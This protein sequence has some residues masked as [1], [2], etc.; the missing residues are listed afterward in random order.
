MKTP[1]RLESPPRKPERTE[2]ARSPRRWWVVAI[3]VAF[4]VGA[5]AAGAGVYFW[6]QGRASDLEEQLEELGGLE[7]QVAALQGELEEARTTPVDLEEQVAGLQDRLDATRDR[8][9]RTRNRL[10]RT[11]QQFAEMRAAHERALAGLEATRGA[12]L[13]DG[14]HFGYI[15]FV[16]V[17]TSPPTMEFDLAYWFTEGAEE[18]A[19]EDGVIEPG[20][21]LPTGYYVRNLNPRLRT[22]VI[23]PEVVVRLVDG[24]LEFAPGLV[25]EEVSLARLATL[26]NEQPEKLVTGL[27]WAIL[28]GGRVTLIEEQ[29]HA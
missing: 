18:A 22:L 29:W 17:Q 21:P 10:Q 7:A 4:L 11:R 15:V 1:T 26:V 19:I 25:G 12:P 14:R 5:G 13:S 3:V 24:P 23:D 2:P 6:Q 16:D 28:E 8:L 9:T 27:F 20:E